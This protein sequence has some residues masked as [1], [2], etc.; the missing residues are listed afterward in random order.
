MKRNFYQLFATAPTHPR[1]WTLA[2][3]CHMSVA[4]F[5]Q[6]TGPYP[7]GSPPVRPTPNTVYYTTGPREGLPTYLDPVR[8]DKVPPDGISRGQLGEQ[9]ELVFKT[10]EPEF[11]LD[12]A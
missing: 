10:L 3:A 11:G 1:W 8:D 7:F 4:S 2:L 9:R 5:A 6:T 12:E